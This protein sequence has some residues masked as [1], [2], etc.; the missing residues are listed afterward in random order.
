[1]HLHPKNSRAICR[2]QILSLS[3]SLSLSLSFF[4]SLFFPLSLSLSLYTHTH[5]SSDFRARISSS[6]GDLRS[7]IQRRVRAAS[8]IKHEGAI[9]TNTGGNDLGMTPV[10]LSW[11]QVI[12]FDH[13]LASVVY[14]TVLYSTVLRIFYFDAVQPTK[15]DGILEKFPKP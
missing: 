9:I 13:L 12:R 2:A 14:C 5:T 1:M 6:L 10:E 11:E 15:S 7:D 8:N 3:I 4:L